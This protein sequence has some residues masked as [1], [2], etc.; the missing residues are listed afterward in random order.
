MHNFTINDIYCTFIEYNAQR[1][2]KKQVHNMQNSA[3][4]C[5]GNILDFKLKSVIMI[6]NIHKKY[7]VDL[8]P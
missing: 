4:P 5:I 2:F 6:Y 7:Y 3:L 8:H 1:N